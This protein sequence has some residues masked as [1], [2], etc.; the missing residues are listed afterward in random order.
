MAGAG[1][2]AGDRK[3]VGDSYATVRSHVLASGKLLPQ[4]ASGNTKA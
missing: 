1:T 3:P 2:P 4:Q